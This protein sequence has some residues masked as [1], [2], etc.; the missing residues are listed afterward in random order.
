MT[1]VSIIITT[2]SRPSLIGR[3]VES[4][5]CAGSN[6]EVIVVDDGST[7][8][9]ADVCSGFEGITY[10]RLDRN[11][12]TAGARNVGILAS[13]S[14]Y[15]SFLDDDD[16]RLPGS[17]DEQVAI[18]ERDPSYGFVYGQVLLAD[19]DGIIL[20]KP[21]IPEETLE[22]DI[23]FQLLGFPFIPNQS[24]VFRKS[25]LLRVGMLDSGISGT[26]DWDIWIRIAELYRVA[27]VRKPVAVWRQPT[28]E[29]G[30]GTSNITN[31]LEMAIRTYHRRWS[32]LPKFTSAAVEKQRFVDNEFEKRIGSWILDDVYFAR[33]IR[34]T[35]SK[36]RTLLTFFP[37]YLFRS[38]FYKTLGRKAFHG[39][40]G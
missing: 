34:S 39:I 12:H 7:D 36:V 25:C 13:T 28:F 40:K 18:L 27:V 4:A 32:K 37:S 19:Q 31:L 1:R 6:V 3:A 5:L 14:P 38:R 29:S 30:Q 22:G 10:I 26:D 23:F 24:V 11:Q 20:P 33:G 8:A 17:L 15:I 2:Y 9:T 35:I 21:P 16:W